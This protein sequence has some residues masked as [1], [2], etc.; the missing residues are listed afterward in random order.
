LTIPR[1]Q[2]AHITKRYPSVVANSD[3]SLTVQPG[4]T[5]AVLGENGAG[6]STLMKIIYGAVKPDEGSVMFNGQPVHIRNPQEA[7]ALGISMV[8]Q[9]FSLFDTLTVAENVWLGLDKSL[10]L[11]QVTHSISAKA[12][13]YGLDV[14]P[15]RPVHTLSVGEM[16]RVEIIRA[17]LTNPKLLILDEPTSVL[18]PQAVEKLFVVLKQLASEGCS[19]LYIS[20]KLHEIRE[21]C[22]ACTVLRGGKVTGVAD[23]RRESNASLSRL[24]IGAEPPELE[25]H[26][27]TPGEVVL[28]VQNLTLP[29]EDQ[30]GHDLDDISF[31]VR[32]GEVVGIAGVSGNGQRELL[33][34]LSGEDTRAA[35]AMIQVGAK[36]VGRFGPA[37]RRHL[38]LHFV[39]EERLGRGAVPTL[40]LAQNLLLTRTD[41]VGKSG[42]IRTGVLRQQAA[43]IIRRFNVKAGGPDAAARSLSG[44]NLQKFIVGREIDANPKLLIVSQPTWGVD[45]GA[46]AQIRGAILA[47]RDAGCAVLV[48]SEELD[49]LFEITDRLHVIAKGRLSPSIDRARATVTQ[50]GEWMSG[51][52]VVHPLRDAGSAPTPTLPQRG[53]E[54]DQGS[55]HV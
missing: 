24:M 40:G 35:P 27:R 37:H 6:K 28:K 53:R 46:S 54:Q 10:T 32:A 38:G 55:S 45:V 13:E 43:D 20:H 36:P 2:L 21:L 34:A 50:I 7:R 14:D 30:F 33:Y 12:R 17:L 8:F 47:L 15:S 11:Q 22:T 9:H 5:H 39:P 42:W 41:A 23:P 49:E 18:T 29:R 1:L 26:A 52:W 16:Q 3:V 4:E 25:H 31:E 19:I 51:L 44:G 48:V